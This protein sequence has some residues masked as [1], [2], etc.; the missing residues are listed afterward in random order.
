MGSRNP[1]DKVGVCYADDML[2]HER[3]PTAMIM[4]S[5]I[6]RAL[7]RMHPEM[8][9][10]NPD[11]AWRELGKALGCL[12]YLPDVVIE[13]MHPLAK[14]GEIDNVFREA[15]KQDAGDMIAYRAWEKVISKDVEA[16]RARVAL[17]AQC[18]GG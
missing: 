7:G 13:H 4:S 3:F 1:G 14:K 10:G 12:I 18:A 2:K 9:H 11:Q 5:V 8:Y 6:I 15:H 16:V 17:E